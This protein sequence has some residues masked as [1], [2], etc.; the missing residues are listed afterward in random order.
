MN[1]EIQELINTHEWQLNKPDRKELKRRVKIDKLI[2]KEMV[3]INKYLDFLK[4]IKLENQIKIL[5]VFGRIDIDSET[6]Y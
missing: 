3:S 4:S 1:D 6:D 5:G 2:N